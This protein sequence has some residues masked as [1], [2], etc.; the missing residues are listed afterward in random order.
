MKI[1]IKNIF[2]VVADDKIY[3]FYLF[4]IFLWWI[5][6]RFKNSSR[7]FKDQKYIGLKINYKVEFLIILI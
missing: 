1:K 4:V 5:F 7:W 3:I 6:N 2:V